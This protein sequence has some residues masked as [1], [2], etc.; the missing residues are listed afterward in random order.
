MIGPTSQTRSPPARSADAGAGSAGAGGRLT[1]DR[2]LMNRKTITDPQRRWFAGE[3]AEWRAEGV[4]SPEQAERLAARYET[5]AEVDSRKRS[6]F[7]FALQ[8]VAALLTGLAVLLLIGFNW[9]DFPRWAKLTIVLATVA[10]VHAA[11]FVLRSRERTAAAADETGQE[12][13]RHLSEVAF[14][15]G[16]LLYGAG[17]WLVAQ[18]FHL[19]AH[20]PDGVWWW[21]V[22][23]LPFALC[24]NTALCHTL[25]VALTALWAGMEVLGFMHLSGAPWGGWRWPNG[26]YSL[27]LFALPALAWAYR[28]RSPVAVGLS[29]GLLAWWAILQ[30]ITW[31]AEAGAF[32]AVGGVGVVLLMLSEAHRRG[33]PLGIPYRIWGGLIVAG[34]LIP[35]SYDDFWHEILLARAFGGPSG[36]RLLVDLAA[37]ALPF[38]AALGILGWEAFRRGSRGLDLHEMRRRYGFPLALGALLAALALWSFTATNTAATRLPPRCWRTGR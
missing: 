27:P 7:V 18:A 23:V 38:T 1:D 11:G 34:I 16:C 15:L 4:I 9:E 30:P 36:S 21:A 3:L 24:L 26:A 33:D 14:F 31:G 5:G 19:D 32:W 28:K 6:T 17:I 8:S 37:T 25:L 35:L 29:A 20:Y 10:G 22:G 13:P 12:P 2:S